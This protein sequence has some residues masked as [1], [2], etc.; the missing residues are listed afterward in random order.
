MN[1]QQKINGTI[2]RFLYQDLESGY[3]I[4]VLGTGSEKA[5]VRGKLPPLHEGQEV[6]VG[7]QWVYDPKYGRQFEASQCK[8]HLPTT[9]SG[10]KKF[11]G[12]GLIKGIGKVYAEKMVNRFGEDVLKVIDKNPTRLSEISGLGPRRVET[13]ISGWQE[14]KEIADV[15][16]F[17]Q[18]KGLSPSLAGR[19]YK[20][21]KHNTVPFI[22]QNPYRLAEEMWGIGFKTADE[23][24]QKMG[25]RVDAPQRIMAG[26]LFAFVQGMSRGHLYL[27]VQDLKKEVL[28][29]LALE[30]T[31]EH[32]KQVKGALTRLYEERK[33]TF[34]SRGDNHYFASMRCYT[35]EK[36]VAQKLQALLAQPSPYQFDINRYYKELNVPTDSLVLNEKQIKGIISALSEKC[37]II[38]GGPGTGKT[39]LIK[40]LLTILEK[41]RVR[42]K[43]A[44]PTGRAA[45]RI[46]EGTGRSAATIHRLLDFDPITR[47]FKHNEIHALN[48][49]F[50]IIDEASMIDIFLAH[51]LLKAMPLNA[52]LVLIGDIDQLPAVGAGNF[53]HDCIASGTIPT[54]RLT[55][56]FRQAQGSLI[57]TNAH[58]VNRGEFPTSFIPGARRDFTF[59]K[60]SNPQNLIG[61]LKKIYTS[62]L[63]SHNI[64]PSQS[65]V[66]T[67]MN[68]G[69]AGTQLINHQLQGFLN[70]QAPAQVM[71]NGITF[72]EGD[73]VMQIR[74]NYDKF[75][76]NGDC[77]CIESINTNDRQLQVNFGHRTV[78]YEFSELYELVLAYAISIHKSQGSEYPAVIVPIYIQHF[79]LLQRNLLY[80]AITRAKRLCILIGETRAIGMALNNDKG[81][82]RNTFL[83]EFLATP[84]E[85]AG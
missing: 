12:S 62:T 35:S 11:L 50:L 8:L 74:N 26:I 60:D 22:L 1:E 9:T 18:D 61:H 39:T 64:L 58:R 81:I 31:E 59:I 53:L 82:K 6:E 66:L 63:Q 17:L 42:Y 78:T 49:D 52:H 56:V 54:I 20:K 19:I 43:L 71:F 67:P 48:V 16:V 72:R 14:H 55:D 15:M 32:L 3:V 41:S 44:A 80:T 76:F 25:W 28:S 30:E 57:I 70:P 47:R 10:L 68:R 23:I 51:S 69:S 84:D 85:S 33:V 65:I 13:I 45:K 38:T 40:K 34:L 24:A 73:R 79:T 36:G 27:E 4:F 7:G 29:L 46:T 2:D 21:Y 77:G 75:V 5:T 83:H 37:T